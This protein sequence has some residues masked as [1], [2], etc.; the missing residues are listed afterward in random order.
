MHFRDPVYVLEHINL[1]GCCLVTIVLMVDPMAFLVN[2]WF[3]RGIH[4][5]WTCIITLMT[6]GTV[7]FVALL[8]LA[9]ISL[10]LSHICQRLARLLD[11]YGNHPRRPILIGFHGFKT[12]GKD[13]AANLLG[14]EFE[15]CRM[16]FAG[17][18][19]DGAAKIFDLT[20]AQVHGDDKETLIPDLELTP[21]QILQRLGTEG[22]RNV[23]GGDIFV[24]LMS[25]RL[26]N[27]MMPTSKYQIV[28]ITDVRFP[29]EAALI[30][31]LGG[32]VI[33]I[34]RTMA[35]VLK[36]EHDSEKP[37]HPSWIDHVVKNDAA[38]MDMKGP[39]TS[40]AAQA[41]N[42]ATPDE[43]KLW[44]FSVI[45]KFHLENPNGYEKKTESM[46]VDMLKAVNIL[47]RNTME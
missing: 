4:I 29:E 18:L 36:P 9:G 37:L 15:I 11:K 23:F 25:R 6:S 7:H 34:D 41:W 22:M 16:A 12:A 46:P 1:T 33:R 40:I 43:Q 26:V 14:M 35:N 10:M 28:V 17:P 19:K 2:P 47:T 8:L 3:W 27:V 24:R 38:I 30:K 45:A 39:L 5:I 21:R 44:A 31:S 32:L 13:T 42:E 20:H